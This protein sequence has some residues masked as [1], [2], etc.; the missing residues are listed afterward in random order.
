MTE[1]LRVAGCAALVPLAYCA[2]LMVAGCAAPTKWEGPTW[3]KS[4]SAMTWRTR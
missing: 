3:D 1:L 2:I 4:K